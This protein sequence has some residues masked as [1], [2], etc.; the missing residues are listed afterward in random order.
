MGSGE[1]QSP[2]AGAREASLLP[3]RQDRAGGSAEPSDCAGNSGTGA[4][5]TRA[6]VEVLR[7][8]AV[9]SAGRDLRAPRRGTG[10]RDAGRLGGR[11]ERPA[12]AAGGSA[13]ASR[14]ERD[15]AACR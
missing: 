6:G 10:S 8:F 15:E 1:F 9:V 7:S 2:S 13:T 14:D 5:G 3:L 11:R 4:V 12:S